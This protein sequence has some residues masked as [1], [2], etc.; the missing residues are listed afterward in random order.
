M[1]I[2]E[3]ESGFHCSVLK[4]IPFLRIWQFWLSLITFLRLGNHGNGC[5][6]FVSFSQNRKEFFEMKSKQNN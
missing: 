5:K 2:Q 1:R 3:K 6:S 4:S